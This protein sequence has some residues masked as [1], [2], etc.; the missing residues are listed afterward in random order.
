MS[1]TPTRLGLLSIVALPLMLACGGDSS[2]PP[3]V[4]SID[5]LGPTADIQIG[6]T[7]QLSATAKDA[8]GNTLTGKTVSWSTSSGA[9]ATVSTNGLVTGVSA[10]TVSITASVD[11]KTMSRDVKVVSSPVGA[12]AVTVASTAIAIGGTTQATAVLRD[13]SGNV[14]TGRTVTWSSSNNTVATVNGTGLVTGVGQGKATISA[15]ADGQ[16]GSV[17]VSVDPPTVAS[18]SPSPM[19]EG[20]PATITGTKFGPTP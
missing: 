4:A 9:I 10:G 16:M 3:S 2:G 7:V 19:I 6:G 17:E 5:I 13:A 8:K 18:V 15:T 11:G 14:I 20:Q 1:M 12:I